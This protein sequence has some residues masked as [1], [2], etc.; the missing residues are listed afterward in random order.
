MKK[1]FAKPAT[2]AGEVLV[3]V[4]GGTVKV[5]AGAVDYGVFMPMQYAGEKA[6]E[7]GVALVGKVQRIQKKRELTKKADKCL[8][9]RNAMRSLSQ[10][11]VPIM[12]HSYVRVVNAEQH[13]RTQAS[14]L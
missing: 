10:M 11:G 7:L 6:Y 2:Y 4:L 5:A 3:T 9:A 8:R 12:N 13:Y 14:Q 1:Q